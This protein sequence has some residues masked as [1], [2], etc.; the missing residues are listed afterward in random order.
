MGWSAIGD[1]P[2][3][4]RPSHAIRRGC[5]RRI[6]RPRGPRG[7][8][9]RSL[10][11]QPGGFEGV[12]NTPHVPDTPGQVGLLPEDTPC[13]T[14]HVSEA[15]GVIPVDSSVSPSTRVPVEQA[16]AERFGPIRHSG[17]Y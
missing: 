1:P 17:R 3:L 13:L 7:R 2:M 9:L 6:T 10:V 12:K 14:G 5:V 4:V 8:V 16:E 11:P 15:T